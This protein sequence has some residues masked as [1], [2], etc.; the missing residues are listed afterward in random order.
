MPNLI[1]KSVTVSI[2]EG[3]EYGS[4]LVSVGAMG[5]LAPKILMEKVILSNCR[6]NLLGMC[7]KFIKTQHPKFQILTRSLYGV[8]F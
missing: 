6:K 7:K 8:D 2:L 1:K 5:A 3:R 4:S